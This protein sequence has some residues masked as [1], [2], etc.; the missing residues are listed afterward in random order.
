MITWPMFAEQ[1]L[2]E[3]LV[4]QILETGVRVGAQAV[5]HLGEEEKPEMMVMRGGIKEAILRLAEETFEERVEGRGLIIRGWA[6]QVLIL[7]NRSVG[8]FLTNCGWN[9]TL[10]GVCAGVLMTTWPM[11]AEQFYVEKFIVYVLK[12]GVRIR[13]E[14]GARPGAV[15]ARSNTLVKWDQVKK[16]I[17]NSMD[18]DE[19]EGRE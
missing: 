16:S 8:G 11:F 15:E 12:I 19:E 5:I 2:N 4:V 18:D 10:E 9:S 14:V 3:K 6:P 17:E 13:V 7:S 1:F